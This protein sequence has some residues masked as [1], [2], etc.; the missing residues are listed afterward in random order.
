MIY[1]ISAIGIFVAAIVFLLWVAGAQGPKGD[2]EPQEIIT[3]ILLLASL[4]V[5]LAKRYSPAD[6]HWAYATIGTIVGFWLHVS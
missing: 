4:F 6:K 3:G 5:I 2:A 1:R